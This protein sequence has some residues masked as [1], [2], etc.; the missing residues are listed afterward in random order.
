MR[1][2]DSSH[3]SGRALVVARS[4]SS[5]RA[6]VVCALASLLVGLLAPRARAQITPPG[7]GEA[8]SAAWSAVGLKQ[9]L[10]E[11]HRRAY[12]GYVGVGATHAGHE[13]HP[14]AHPSILVVTHE[15]SDHVRPHSLAS[16]GLSYRR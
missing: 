15:L 8:E 12:L 5:P 10:D 16:L 3:R 2:V 7:M 9:S 14:Y 4:L 6:A 11:E 13:Q 1:K